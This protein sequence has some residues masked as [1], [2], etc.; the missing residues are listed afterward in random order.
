M[1]GLIVRDRARYTEPDSRPPHGPKNVAGEIRRAYIA[2]RISEEA[3]HEAG[4]YNGKKCNSRNPSLKS[5][6]AIAALEPDYRP[7]DDWG[8]ENQAIDS[9]EHSAVA[10]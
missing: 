6:D 7:P 4:P 1:P 8:C 2:S 9:I 5:P 3:R 10:R